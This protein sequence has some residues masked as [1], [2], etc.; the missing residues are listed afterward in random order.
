M[1]KEVKYII[2]QII[3]KNI[4]DH[5]QCLSDQDEGR[6]IAGGE[7]KILIAAAQR[8]EGVGRDQLSVLAGYKRSSRDTYIQRLQ[9][10]GL[11]DVCDGNIVA[12]QAGMDALGSDFEPLPAGDELRSYWLQRLPTGERA[13]LQILIAAHPN[14]VERDAISQATGYL[15]S[16]RDTYLQRLASRR[17]IEVVG[18][19]AVKASDELF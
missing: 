7:R 10:R 13:I 15:R 17:V 8:P 14:P 9:A 3:T 2:P 6:S 12:T 16:S 11:V 1:A 18:R 19:G 5:T 4:H